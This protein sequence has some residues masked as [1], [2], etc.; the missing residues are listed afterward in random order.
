MLPNPTSSERGYR[1]SASIETPR[2]TVSR[3]FPR[4][5]RL[6]EGGDGNP[7]GYRVRNAT[8]VMKMGKKMRLPELAG[9][10]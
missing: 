9:D 1:N 7:F 5:V 6:L 3:G 8:G 4:K 2:L 10:T